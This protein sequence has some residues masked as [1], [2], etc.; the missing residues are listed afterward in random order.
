MIVKT[1]SLDYEGSEEDQLKRIHSDEK[2]R[3]ERH[4]RR[5]ELA[6]LRRKQRRVNSR[7]QYASLFSSRHLV[8]LS[9]N[10]SRLVLTVPAEFSFDKNYEESAAVI[11]GI[12]DAILNQR[13]PVFLD[14]SNVA[15]VGAAAALVLT[16]EIFR[17]RTS[18]ILPRG[19]RAVSGSYPKFVVPHKILD[20]LGFY[21]AIQ[22]ESYMPPPDLTAS[23]IHIGMQSYTR[24]DAA[25]ID[26][27]RTV[28]SEPFEQLKQIYKQRLQG[29]VVE[30][31]SNSFEHAFKSAADFRMLSQRAWLSGYIHRSDNEFMMM[32]Y[33]QGAG[34]PRTLD[35]T[36][37]ERLRS[38]G[39]L[40]QPS[41]SDMISAA[42]DIYRTST[43]Q[44][45]RGR[46]FQT[47]KR[48]I[49]ICEDG[50]LR[51]LS[52]RGRYVYNRQGAQ[53]AKDANQSL[54]GTLVQ[55]RIKHQAKEIKGVEQ[56]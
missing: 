5:V 46:G 10:V 33:D 25:Q 53:V 1:F 50:E 35:P 6:E 20:D 26:A 2:I 45:S 34:I 4:R 52:N 11:N 47:M 31:V 3:I 37:L 44:A 24:I 29:A 21:R 40:L 36:V 23:H 9:D 32:V 51:V 17:S 27:F 55:W 12:R 49:D 14:F 41:D 43:G 8:R 16:A 18:L 30:A 48:F 28:F 56:E 22:V 38:V 13:T 42:T 15:Y 54:G 7:A 19:R 39:S